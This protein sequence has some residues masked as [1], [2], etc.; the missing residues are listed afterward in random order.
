M[1]LLLI[2]SVNSQYH[3]YE[4]EY[5]TSEEGCSFRSYKERS[6]VIFKARSYGV[7]NRYE[8]IATYE[9]IMEEIV[10]VISRR[11]LPKERV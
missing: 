5:E 4:E 6:T 8:G 7:Q 11:S 3:D 2:Q 9:Q 10:R 1:F